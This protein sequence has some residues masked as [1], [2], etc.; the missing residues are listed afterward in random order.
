MRYLLALTLLCLLAACQSG[1]PPEPEGPTLGPLPILPGAIALDEAPGIALAQVAQVHRQTIRES[2]DRYFHDPR[3]LVET[4]DAYD[5][6][7]AALSWRLVDVLEFG[8]GG[9]VR[10]YHRGQERAILAFHP[11]DDGGTD[12][13]LMAGT[14]P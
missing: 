6:A 3:G 11:A 2:E 10:R 4:I 9:F 7:L 14:L 13:F 12:F 8:D 1:P 5:T